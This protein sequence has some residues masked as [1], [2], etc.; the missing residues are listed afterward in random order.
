MSR[1]AKG[2]N[3]MGDPVLVQ[4]IDRFT[5]AALPIAEGEMTRDLA[6]GFADDDPAWRGYGTTREAFY[7]VFQELRDLAIQTER[8]RHLQVIDITPAQRILAQHHRAYREAWG[9]LAGVGDDE[10]DTPP[11]VGEWPLRVTLAHMFAAE[12]GFRRLIMHALERRHNAE[13][14][15]HP[16]P[17]DLDDEAYMAAVRGSVAEIRAR[18]DTLHDSVLDAFAALSDADLAAP[19]WFWEGYALPIRFRLYR[20]EAHLREHTIQID[21]TLPGIGHEPGEAERLVR[22]I[23][24]ALGEAEG[25]A[26]G[27]PSAG[28]IERERVATL[29]ERVS[30]YLTT[31]PPAP[32]LDGEGE[33]GTIAL[34][35]DS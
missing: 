16:A 6:A 2:R 32:L 13:L 33:L 18:F 22:L 12:R 29:T 10:L 3:L 34:T 21:K 9:A 7:R 19:S 8:E 27:A 28:A 26:I 17:D 31:S 20:F 4:A 11:G 30:G 23:Y 1:R 35:V 5:R 15:E 24:A 14:P 25:A